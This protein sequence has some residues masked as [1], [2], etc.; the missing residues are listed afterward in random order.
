MDSLE[1]ECYDLFN[2]LH[3]NGDIS[4]ILNRVSPET[5]FYWFKMAAHVKCHYPFQILDD[6]ENDIESHSPKIE[7]NNIKIFQSS[8]C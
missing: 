1:I 6:E 3:V 8:K 5:S 2:K 4:D 7:K